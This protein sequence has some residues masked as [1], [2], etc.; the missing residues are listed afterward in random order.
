MA[1]CVIIDLGWIN[2]KRFYS[3]GQSVDEPGKSWMASSFNP[4]MIDSRL[5]GYSTARLEHTVC[6]LYDTARWLNKVQDR[7]KRDATQPASQPA[8]REGSSE[9]VRTYGIVKSFLPT[10]PLLAGANGR[11]TSPAVR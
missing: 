11:E 9:Y 4:V 7:E 6:L 8:N 2:I 1:D 10:R 3:G 5:S